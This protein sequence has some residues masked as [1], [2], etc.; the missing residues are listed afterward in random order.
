MRILKR[1]REERKEGTAKRDKY[2]N[3]RLFFL[4]LGIIISYDINE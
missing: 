1:K 3:W 2:E 4:F